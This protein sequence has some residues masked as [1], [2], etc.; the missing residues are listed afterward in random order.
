MDKARNAIESIRA[1]L[2]PAA[3]QDENKCRNCPN[4]MMCG[5]IDS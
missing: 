5:E 1:G 2:F 3:P 4:E